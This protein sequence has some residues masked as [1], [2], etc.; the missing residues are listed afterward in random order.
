MNKLKIFFYI[1]NGKIIIYLLPLTDLLR[2]GS[3]WMWHD[4]NYVL[5]NGFYLDKTI[6]YHKT[7]KEMFAHS[8]IKV[9]E[10]E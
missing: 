3:E 4:W 9:K 8:L 10:C 1:P 6:K 5:F 7:H 2:W